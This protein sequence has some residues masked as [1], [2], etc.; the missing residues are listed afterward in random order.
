MLVWRVRH[1]EIT[2]C[3]VFNGQGA[4]GAGADVA[5]LA[6]KLD[7]NKTRNEAP[8]STTKRVTPII[9]LSFKSVLLLLVLYEINCSLLHLGKNT[10]GP[11]SSTPVTYI[12]RYDFKSIQILPDVV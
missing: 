3:V 11:V 8:L 1:A 2:A 9:R 7:V 5:A 10:P 6:P 12:M 4:G